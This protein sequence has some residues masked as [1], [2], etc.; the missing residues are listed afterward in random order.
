MNNGICFCFAK[1]TKRGNVN[2]TM[3]T[4]IAKGMKTVCDKGLILIGDQADG[5]VIFLCHDWCLESQRKTRS[6]NKVKG[7]T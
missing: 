5:T 6:P 7:T 1:R 4:R 3:D 2:P